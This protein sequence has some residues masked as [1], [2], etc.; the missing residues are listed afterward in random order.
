MNKII[1]IKHLKKYFKDIKA[2][3]D[4]SFN[5]KKG[6]LF[7]FLGVNGAGKSTT[8]NILVGVLKK[9]AG[10]CYI[11]GQS[12][13][14]IEKIL[15]HIGIVFQNSLLDKKL[16]VYDN[17][18]YRAICYELDKDTFNKNLKYLCQNLELTPL[19]KRPLHKL[20]GGQKRKVDIARALIHMP[21][22]LILD[23]PTTGLDPMTRKL[24]W[25][26]IEKLQKERHLT[27]ILTT[28]D[29]QDIEALTNRILLIGKGKILLDGSLAELKT[30]NFAHK[31]LTIDYLGENIPITEHMT[32]VKDLNG[33][34]EIV[35]DT[36]F[37][38]VSQAVSY[39]S[40]KVDVRD[41][42]VMGETVDEMVVSLYK[43]FEI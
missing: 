27:V 9:D 5:V 30:R 10:D 28:H 1:E 3:D 14:H 2:V 18:K 22:I 41:L 25:N 6:E 35:I 38:T 26:L 20:S 8:I 15:P 31:T 11:E 21:N 19:L 37:L 12:I 7:A 39:I 16:T 33:H 32:V 43:E 17:L 13:E 4:I 34:A 42:S 40:A 24:V 29:M 36:E 23:E